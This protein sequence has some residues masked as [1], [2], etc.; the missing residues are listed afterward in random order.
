VVALQRNKRCT[1]YISCCRLI[2][3]T[4]AYNLFVLSLQVRRNENVLS[5]RSILHTRLSLM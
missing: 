2:D 3:R 1:N 4:T 5:A